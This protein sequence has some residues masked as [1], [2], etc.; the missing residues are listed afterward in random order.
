M[1]TEERVNHTIKNVTWGSVNSLVLCVMPFIVR[2]VMMKFWGIEYV[3]L[4]VLFA[5]ILTVLNLAELGL[6]PALVYNMYLPVAKKDYDTVNKLISLYSK[7]YRIVGLSILLIG[8]I[9]LP[10]LPRL[11]TG[12][13]PD[14]INIYVVYLFYLF[15]TAVGYL[16]WPYV[17]VLFIANLDTT[18]YS[19]VS[20]IVWIVTYSIQIII[21][22][23]IK[24]Y[25]L[26]A[27]LLPVGAF[28]V[29]YFMYRKYL[30]KYP[31]YRIIKLGKNSF[32]DEF[33]SDFLKKVCGVVMCKVRIAFRES[34]DTLI[35]SMSLGL[36][37]VAIYNNYLMIMT[38]PIILIKTLC[39]SV[40]PVL[41]NGMAIE[42]SES[43][44]GVKKLF[45]FVINW[46]AT[47]A[48]AFLIVFYQ[49]FMLIW[50]KEEN[51]ASFMV[52]VLFTVLFYLRSLE[53]VNDVIKSTSGIW[54][55]GK[56]VSVVETIV[57]LI[58]NVVFVR[59]WGIEGIIFATVLSMTV[60][61]IPFETYYT[62]KY[63]FKLNPI[64]D[65]LRMIV[66]AGIAFFCV[67]ITYI[68]SNMYSDKFIVQLIIKIFVSLIVPNIILILFYFKDERFKEVFKIC[69]EALL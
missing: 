57:N 2:T 63:Y 47:W 15:Q 14:G 28:L 16:S 36:V 18:V 25:Y 31:E 35:I 45:S 40:L 56:W 65:M 43:N 24:N 29:N 21:I 59:I 42:T 55:Q 19:K 54:W 9:I 64:R 6:G 62:Y 50:A 48:A 33:K 38:V 69:K 61:N 68:I 12:S 10:I 17:Q 39:D 51:M 32:N 37:S 30:S 11:V 34:V 7:A 5:S 66:D 49:D 8:L 13:Y 60:F 53:K 22:F 58:L 23:L 44:Y 20:S 46:F 41:G 67:F 26:Y 4:G 27:S 52:A 1:A 3:G